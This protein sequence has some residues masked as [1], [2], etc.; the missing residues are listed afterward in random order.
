[1]NIKWNQNGFHADLAFGGLDISSNEE[2]GF[3]P[4]QLM[5]ASIAACSGTVLQNILEKKRIQLEE[6]TIQ[7]KEER[8]PEEAGRIKSIHL[9]FIVKGKNLKA[10][11]MKKALRIALKN[12]S[13]ARSVEN[14]IDIKETFEIE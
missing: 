5:L 2:A 12:C 10:E 14:C 8:V 11:H 1:M 6:M 9:H 7:T 4:Y 13:M 3:R